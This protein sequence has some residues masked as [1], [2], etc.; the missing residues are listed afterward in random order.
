MEE[1]NPNLGYAHFP[2]A[3]RRDWWGCWGGREVAGVASLSMALPSRSEAASPFR[4]SLPRAG[5]R[6]LSLPNLA[7]KADPKRWT[8]CVQRVC[9][10]VFGVSA[11]SGRSEERCVEATTGW[12]KGDCDGRME[13]KG[14]VRMMCGGV[15]VG[16][17]H[18]HG[19][20]YFSAGAGIPEFACLAPLRCYHYQHL[21]KPHLPLI[22]FLSHSTVRDAPCR[23]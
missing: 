14:I 3:R 10:L 2:A 12:G 11:V 5:R 15:G 23:V 18:G 21:L 6:L 7:K 9:S 4:A 22:F 16:T 17:H 20:T 13:R 1:A 8:N 19:W